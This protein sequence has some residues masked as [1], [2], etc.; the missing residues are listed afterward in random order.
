MQKKYKTLMTLGMM[1]LALGGVV[2]RVL[3]QTGLVSVD[4]TDAIQ[5]LFI[6]MSIALN[7]VAARGRCTPAP[8]TGN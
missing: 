7:I 1:C 2:P 6:G 8:F 3:H 4:F 5:G